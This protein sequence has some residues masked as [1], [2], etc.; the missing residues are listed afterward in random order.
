M[1]ILYEYIIYYI[2]IIYYYIILVCI[3]RL[4]IV[5]V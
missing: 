5:V 4:Y 2:L 3:Y 1:N